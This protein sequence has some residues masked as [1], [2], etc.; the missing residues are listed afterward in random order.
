MAYVALSRVRTLNGLYIVN[1]NVKSIVANEKAIKE[2]ERLQNL[3][4]DRHQDGNK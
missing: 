4:R 1:F 2:D 3:E